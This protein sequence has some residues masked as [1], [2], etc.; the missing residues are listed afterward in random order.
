VL[1]STQVRTANFDMTESPIFLTEANDEQYL[2]L[3]SVKKK[4]LRLV[5]TERW[6]SRNKETMQNQDCW[7]DTSW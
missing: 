1:S 3:M 7:V 2:L 6:Q 4:L 5:T